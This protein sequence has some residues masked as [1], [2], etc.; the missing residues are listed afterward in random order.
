MT[1]FTAM[2][3]A[4]L[5]E[6]A[7]SHDIDLSLIDA[8]KKDE[9]LNAIDAQTTRYEMS[10]DEIEAENAKLAGMSVD[11]TE[12]EGTTSV[13]QVRAD[14][15]YQWSE[16]NTETEYDVPVATT[17]TATTTLEELTAEDLVNDRNR[18]RVVLNAFPITVDG[19]RETRLVIAYVPGEDDQLAAAWWKNVEGHP[20]L[21]AGVQRISTY[22]T[23]SFTTLDGVVHDY[24]EGGNCGC[25]NR[26]KNWKPWGY[27]V[28]IVQVSQ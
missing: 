20:E 27:G 18:V 5:R 24:V 28:R 2:S 3:A 19:L 16:A 13:E 6:Y 15:G 12:Q 11:V 25:G 21:V 17:A 1:D 23:D 10:E 22:D 8:R 7:H 9:L 26:L 14:L 4:E